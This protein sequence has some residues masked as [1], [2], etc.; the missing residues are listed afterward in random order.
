MTMVMRGR[1]RADEGAQAAEGAPPK[2]FQGFP[3]YSK[4]I[5]SFSKEIPSFFQTFPNF[6]LGGFVR[7][8]RLMA[9]N[10][11]MR[12]SPE[13][14]GAGRVPPARDDPAIDRAKG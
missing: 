5:P 10:E 9:R 7:F 4:E 2:F 6:F 1:L 3:S 14:P 8:Q 13:F 12:P 11:E